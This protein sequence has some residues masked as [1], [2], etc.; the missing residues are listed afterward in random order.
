MPGE[1]ILAADAE[2]ALAAMV[3]GIDR[4]P[5]D[6]PWV[7]VGGLAVQLQLR[8]LHRAT[9]DADMVARD[10]ERLLD[11]L[12]A[13]GARV[14]GPRAVFDEEA[15]NVDV[16]DSAES[17]PLPPVTSPVARPFA[18]AR[19]WVMVANDEI[20]LVVKDGEDVVATTRLKVA[21][22]PAL[23]A[24]KMVSVLGRYGSPSADKAAT[25]I[26]DMYLLATGA[27]LEGVARE[28]VA[29]DGELARWLGAHLAKNFDANRPE[30]DDRIRELRRSGAAA[31]LEKSD[32]ALL[33]LLG[34]AILDLAAGGEGSA[35]SAP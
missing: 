1:L 13:L 6:P 22:V 14:E 23:I 7:L 31:Q 19:R 16:M 18:L 9:A 29:G 5:R 28:I 20:E 17:E 15:F 35:Q 8:R 26:V 24:L 12:A 33:G 10:Q 34:R 25:D 4:L 3:L 27:E 30:L 11:A 2:G 32:L 21:R